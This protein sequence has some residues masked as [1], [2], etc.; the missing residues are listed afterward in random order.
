MFES[1][2]VEWLQVRVMMLPGLLMG[3]TFHEFGHAWVATRFGDDTPRLMGRVTLS[4]LAHL[5]IMGT[6][7]VLLGG[8]GWAKPVQVNTSRLRPRVWGDIAVSLAGVTMNFFLAIGFYTLCVLSQIPSLV[9]DFYNPVLTETLFYSAY[10][11]MF[12][13]AFNL[14]PI[15]PL[16]GFHVARYLFPPSME[17]VVQTLYRMGPML[18]LLLFVTDYAAPLVGPVY[19]AVFSVVTGLVHLVL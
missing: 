18:L 15:P 17:Y 12:L 19:R 5:D 1:F 11:N 6:I 3:F 10:I 2:T 9:G 4:P 14:L 13:I 16:D 8:F 7:L